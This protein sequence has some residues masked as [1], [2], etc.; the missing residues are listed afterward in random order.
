VQQGENRIMNWKPVYIVG[1]QGFEKAVFDALQYSGI[2]FMPGYLHDELQQGE[3]ALFWIDESMT[4]R[5]FKQAI[6]SKV[7]FRYRLRVFEELEDF[8]HEHRQ[9]E[10]TLVPGY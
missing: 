10:E 1:K 6:T 8:I 2:S 4:L 9:P 3:H 7:V 5:D